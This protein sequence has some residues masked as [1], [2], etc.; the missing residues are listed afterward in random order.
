VN[1]ISS[2]PPLV[3]APSRADFLI[4]DANLVATCAGA[5]PRR[6]AAQGDI[7]PIARASVAASQGT[8]VFVGP[9]D[10]LAATVSLDPDAVRI[11]ARGCTVVPGFVDADGIRVE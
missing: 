6:G 1:D 8:I 11:D 7:A 10:S 2:G 4:H 3:T 9:A 5:A